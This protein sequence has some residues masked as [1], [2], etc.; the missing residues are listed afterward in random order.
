MK[1]GELPAGTK[2]AV[3]IR[4]QKLVGKMEMNAIANDIYFH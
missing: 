2:T 4:T 1:R 3:N